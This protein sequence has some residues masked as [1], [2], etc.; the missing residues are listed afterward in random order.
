VTKAILQFDLDD[1]QERA[2]HKRAV[3]ALDYVLALWEIDQ[4]LRA[5]EKYREFNTEE[6]KE[7]IIEIRAKFYDVLSERDINLDNQGE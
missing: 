6:A 7:L 4:E 1:P 3:R 2:N 5:I